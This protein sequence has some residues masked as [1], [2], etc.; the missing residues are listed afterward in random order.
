MMRSDGIS[1]PKGLFHFQLT[2][3]HPKGWPAP[4]G[5][6]PCKGV[7]GRKGDLLADRE[8]EHESG[9]DKFTIFTIQCVT[10]G[11]NFQKSTGFIY[12]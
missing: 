7:H 8:I 6:H 5:A 2:I 9:R 3:L 11:Q 1:N 4:I 10:N 12:L